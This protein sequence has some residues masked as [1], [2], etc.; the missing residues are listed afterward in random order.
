[1][2]AASATLSWLTSARLDLHRREPVAGDVDDVVDAADDPEVAVLVAPGGVADQVGVP[3][4]AVPIGL[5]EALRLLVERARHR[6]PGPRQDEDAAALGRSPRRASSKIFA[7][8]PGNG[9]VAEPGLV[10]VRPGSGVIMIAPVSVC[11][12]VSTIG[13]RPPPMFSWYQ[14]QAR[15]LIGSP[16]EPSSRSEL[17][18]VL[19][20]VLDAPLH[21]GADRGRGRVEDRHLVALDDLPPAV[22]G[23]VVGRA[24]V[25]HDGRAVGER[26]V[27]D[28]AVAGDPADVGGAP[29]DVVV[30]EVEDELVGGG[31]PGQVAA[32]SCAGC[33]SACAVEP[34]V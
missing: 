9:T 20:D 27:D 25:H 13:Q 16:T 21:A 28:V 18:V 7:S 24:L 23:R 6:R 33:P 19:L 14:S 17:E 32:R 31:D 1:M 15:G 12:Q 26:A 4:V 30:L 2:T 10:V 34:E 3:A 22:L 29:V 11:H 8:M 5:D